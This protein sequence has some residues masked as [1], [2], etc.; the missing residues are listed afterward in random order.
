MKKIIPL[1]RCIVQI[2]I[3]LSFRFTLRCFHFCCL[4]LCPTIMWRTGKMYIIATWPCRHGKLY[5]QWPRSHEV[6]HH[7]SKGVCTSDQQWA[8]PQEHAGELKAEDQK[9]RVPRAGSSLSSSFLLD[10]EGWE[11]LNPQEQKLWSPWKQRETWQYQ[12]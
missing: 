3:L 7:L 9:E 2:C 10:W 12:I 8:V 11:F 4:Q 6:C 1:C 5:L